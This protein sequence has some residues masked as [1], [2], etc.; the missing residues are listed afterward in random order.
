[1]S[2][3]L[4]LPLFVI[5]MGIGSAAMLVPGFH[6]AATRDFETM[7]VFGYSALLFFALTGLFALATANYKAKDA[8]RSHLLSLLAC[9]AALPLLLAIPLH[10]SVGNT[11]FFNAYFEMVSSITTTGATLYDLPDRLPE[12]VHLWRA[13]VAWM[14]GLFVWITAAAILAPLNIGGFEVM[15]IQ[16]DKIGTSASQITEI[17]DGST[18]LM[19]W[20]RKLVPIYV[21]VTGL[22]WVGLTLAGDR[23]FVALIH[24]MSAMSTS[25]IS[26]TGGLKTS[27]SG[28]VG[29]MLVF[30]VLL[31]GL[32][33]LVFSGEWRD[34]TPKALAKNPEIRIA[35]FLMV[36][37]P[38][39]L[40]VRHWYGA[41]EVD[42]VDDFE[43]SLK[44]LWGG[45]FATISFLTTTGFE[46]S[47][48]DEARDW[49]GLNTPGMIL[50][51]LAIVG[52]G[53]AT[54]AGGVKLL[55]VYA[56]YKNGQRELEKLVHPSSVAGAGGM[57]RHLRRRGAY[58]AWIFF[59]LFAISIA[60]VAA[61]LSLLGH[62]FE[63]AMV[64]T[65]AALST[66][67]P[68]AAT[69][70]ETPI[71]YATLS[72]L[73]KGVLAA[74]MVLGRLETLAFVALFNPESWRN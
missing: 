28:M 58:V 26:A 65:V 56:L 25:G 37:V 31:F 53:V 49:S 35:V 24:A 45:V 12:S 34:R 50:M 29:E 67:G 14:G 61:L 17:A 51:G 48:W 22:L 32:S 64:L 36:C 27:E 72:P 2:R 30:L 42:S 57:A 16:H 54:T 10:Q 20:S 13:L 33:R 21:V 43:T 66:T 40:F 46:G 9:F 8:A 69:A 71:S 47:S 11:T 7:R 38:S 62:S 70:T 74:A 39:L 63:E 59:M 18:R 1:M 6:A 3:L 68:L 19:R 15:T 44:A 41:L 4:H 5:L 52:G 73:A 23:A 55:R 60:V